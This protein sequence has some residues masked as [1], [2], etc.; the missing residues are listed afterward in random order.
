MVK[1]KNVSAP[2]NQFQEYNIYK[3]SIYIYKKISM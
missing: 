2:K 1:E 3:Y